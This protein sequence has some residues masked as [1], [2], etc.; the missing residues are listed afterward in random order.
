MPA[1]F[2][3][4]FTGSLLTDYVE[5]SQNSIMMG[6]SLYIFVRTHIMY[7][8]VDTNVNYGL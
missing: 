1:P 8:R 6:M 3:I 2:L 4:N 7:T 5:S